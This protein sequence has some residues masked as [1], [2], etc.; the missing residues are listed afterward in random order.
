M[1]EI[2][3]GALAAKL[4]KQAKSIAPIKRLEITKSQL[5]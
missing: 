4:F 1:Q 3:F 5:E 2:I